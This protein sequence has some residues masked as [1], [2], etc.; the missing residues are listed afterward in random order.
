MIGMDLL[1]LMYGN[2]MSAIAQATSPQP[3]PNPNPNA[4][5][6]LKNIPG[7]TG[8]IPG[9]GYI[10]PVSG[11]GG[12]VRLPATPAEQR[13]A[14]VGPMAPGGP[15]MAA[16]GPPTPGA[17]NAPPGPPPGQA[18]LPPT[19]ATQSPPDLAQLY[20]QLE[21]R[22]RSA[23]EIDRGLALMAS[24]YAAPGTQ[25]Q[26]MHSMDNLNQDPGAQLSNLIQLQNMQ[27]LQNMPAPGSGGAGGGVG[28]DPTVWAMLPPD[29]KLKYL[30][31]QNTSNLQ[32]Q[33]AAREAQGKDVEDFKN[34]GIQ[35]FSALNQ[36]LTEGESIVD[37]LLKNP[38]ATM[39]AL[40]YPDLLTTSKAAAWLPIGP[41]EAA[42]Q[43]AV[44]IEK[45]EAELT[46]E[47]LS[48][49]KNVRN[50]REFNTL[51]EA[52]TAGLNPNNGQAGV[53]QALQ[54]IKQKMAVAHAQ[55][56]ATAGKEIPNQYAGLA[57]PAYTSP[58]LHGAP[59]PYYTGATYEPA[60]SG[61]GGGGPVQITGPGDIAKLARGT[62]FVI[63]SGPNQGKIGYAQ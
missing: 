61:G 16:G 1:N 7:A 41:S 9:T 48:N 42:K 26:I 20:L 28:V 43:Q 56:Y 17:P 10:A 27:R 15:Q 58:T 37:Q 24:A 4:P 32:V 11:P 51:G 47:S 59:N 50:Q 25:G 54:S 53:V 29:A 12:G 19:A 33:T 57:D 6:Q 3:A 5:P 2:P 36:K 23:N 35:D 60:P 14:Q 46:G 39:T 31:A 34:T 8:A 13:G 44:A 40:Q 62:P 49:V 55:V 52:L 30:E 22:N 38:Q 21:N 45:L 18:G 63:P